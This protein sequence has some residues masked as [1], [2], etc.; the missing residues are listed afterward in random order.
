MPLQKRPCQSPVS[1]NRPWGNAQSG[2]RLIHAESGKVPQVDQRS[3]LL[4]MRLKRA[5]S[6]IKSQPINR[7]VDH[8]RIGQFEINPCSITPSFEPMPRSGAFDQNPPHRDCG[9]L[10]KLLSPGSAVR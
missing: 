5:Q 6:V 10:E 2:G 4:I 3:Q 9:R 8:H 1:V 7:I